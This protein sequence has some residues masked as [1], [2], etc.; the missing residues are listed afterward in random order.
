M[1]SPVSIIIKTIL[2]DTKKLPT[3]WGVDLHFLSGK[4]VEH[5]D[6]RD[7]NLKKDLCYNHCAFSPGLFKVML[8]SLLP[9]LFLNSEHLLFFLISIICDSRILK[10]WNNLICNL[11]TVH[12]SLEIDLYCFISWSVV[13]FSCWVKIL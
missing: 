3:H 13:C 9:P 8:I 6:A 2:V 1:S 7:Q 4:Y 5:F 10:K 12:S 11:F